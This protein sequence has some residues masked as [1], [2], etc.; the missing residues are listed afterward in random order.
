M[1]VEARIYQTSPFYL[2]LFVD[3]SIRGLPFTRARHLQLP[4]DWLSDDQFLVWY[5]HGAHPGI[6]ES[7]QE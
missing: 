5:T 3:E 4:R 1:L 7:I 6:T 2:D